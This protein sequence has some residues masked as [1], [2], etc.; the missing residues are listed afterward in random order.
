MIDP[1]KIF[2][3]MTLEE[4][5]GQLFLQEF[6]GYEKMPEDLIE[7]NKK[8]QLGGIIYF[9]GVNVKDLDQL[10]SLSQDVQSHAKENKWNLPFII[11]LDQEGGQLTAVFRKATTFPGNQA[12][13]FANDTD[14][15]YKQGVHVA[16]ELKY[17]GIN[18]TL[19]PVLDVSYDSKN[20][21]PIPDNRMYSSD[22]KVVAEMGVAY[23]KGI[24][25]Q[26]LIA[27]GK[28]FPGQ[29]LV[30]TDTHF[31]MDT[32]PGDKKRLDEVE[33]YP[34]QKAIDAGVASVLTHHGI[35]ENLDKE[36][37]ATLSPTILQHLR[38]EM[39]FGGLIISDDL[40]MG[41]IVDKYGHEDAIVLAI[42][43]GIDLVISTSEKRWAPEFVAKCV[44]EG[45]IEEET[46]NAACMRILEAKAKYCAEPI[47]EERQVTLEEG[48]KLS[49]EIAQKSLVLHKGDRSKLPLKLKEDEKVGILF[50]NPARLVMSDATNLYDDVSLKQTIDRLGYH[51]NVKEA[52][53]P[54]MPTEMEII[55][56]VDM[57]YIT[58]VVIFTTVNCHR[59]DKQVEVLKEIRKA[60]PNKLVIAVAS[61]SPSDVQI[62]SEYA[63]FVF[64][65]S[66]L[67][68]NQLEALAHAIFGGAEIEHN[69][70]KDL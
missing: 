56:L 51:K 27:C 69:P 20:G 24:Q 65:S 64:A 66:G 10:H 1:K 8:N 46:I 36:N 42:N 58:D 44:R 52:V 61:R 3:E 19:A 63:D 28:H 30:E 17:A 5:C 21:V 18:V 43:A 49:K 48:N 39:G 23:I 34:F 50:G 57:S 45:R 40:I 67:T 59:F 54:W 4:K 37:P 55:S 62:L 32:H 6:K 41:A 22:P 60:H 38:K 12:L 16:N 13:G 47:P 70:A 53:M 2:S 31:E 25:D 11:S 7:L 15:A 9:S 26:G 14:L 29:R 35:F 68:A 33:Y